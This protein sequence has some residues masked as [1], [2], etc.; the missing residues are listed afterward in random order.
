MQCDQ[1]ARIFVILPVIGDLVQVQ[2]VIELFGKQVSERVLYHKNPTK[3]QTLEFCP[4]F[5][6]YNA[7]IFVKKTPI[8]CP[9]FYKKGAHMKNCAHCQC[10]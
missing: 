5:C 8:F 7:R 4:Y 2:S 1:V 6:Q 9:Y 3:P 10:H